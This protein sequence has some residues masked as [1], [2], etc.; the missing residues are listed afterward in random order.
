M[1]YALSK[2]LEN[3]PS[4]MMIRQKVFVE[5]QGFRDEFDDT[6]AA[7]FHVVFFENGHAAATGRLF[8][9]PA[10]SMHIG[11]VAVLKEYRGR[12]LGSLVITTLEKKACDLGCLT[13]ELSA[14]TRVRAFYEKLGYTA[15]GDEYLDESCP[16]IKMVKILKQQ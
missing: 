1:R 12:S 10:A 11:R 7:A 15:E 13:V 16:H 4:A 5:E 8:G 6:D 14:Q 9:D 2:G 3:N